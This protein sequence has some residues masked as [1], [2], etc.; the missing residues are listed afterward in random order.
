MRGNVLRALSSASE[1]PL[2]LY[3]TARNSSAINL[4]RPRYAPFGPAAE[5]SCHERCARPGAE[6]SDGTLLHV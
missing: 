1:S 5:K 6:L 2:E 3:T 4:S